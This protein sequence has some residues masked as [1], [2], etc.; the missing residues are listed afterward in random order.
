[1]NT[2]SGD[3]IC[4]VKTIKNKI[5]T[6]LFLSITFHR[7]RVKGQFHEYATSINV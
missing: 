1:M 6:G 2:V 5:A 3:D 4:H 7:F